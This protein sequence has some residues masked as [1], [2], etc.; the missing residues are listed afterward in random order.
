MKTRSSRVNNAQETRLKHAE[1]TF[2]KLGIREEYAF[3]TRVIR[4]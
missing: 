3:K 2:K 1:Y 4:V